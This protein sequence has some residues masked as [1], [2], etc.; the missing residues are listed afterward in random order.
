MA[1]LDNRVV[2]LV[3]NTELEAL[4]ILCQYEDSQ[5]ALIRRLIREEAEKQKVWAIAKERIKL[6]EPVA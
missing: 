4:K 6:N 2:I 1:R 5:A 3:S